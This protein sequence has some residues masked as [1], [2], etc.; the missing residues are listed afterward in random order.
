MRRRHPTVWLLL[1]SLAAFPVVLGTWFGGLLLFTWLISDPGHPGPPLPVVVGARLVDDDLTFSFGGE[2]EPPFT[3][4][5]SFASYGNMSGLDFAFASNKSLNGFDISSRQSGVVVIQNLPAK[6]DWLQSSAMWVRVQFSDNSSSWMGNIDKHGMSEVALSNQHPYGE[7][8]FS[9][10]G[11]LS[12]S[13]VAA[14]DGVD[15][16]TVCHPANR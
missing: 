9:D 7:F 2:C 14:R 4:Y 8:Y 1:V 16:L 6:F 15:L 10:I 3:V 12:P 5:L 13:E 11:W